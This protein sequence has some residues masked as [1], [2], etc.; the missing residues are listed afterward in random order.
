MIFDIK[1]DDFSRKSRLVSGGHMTE[2][3]DAMTYASVILRET[4]YIA[5]IIAA[6]NRLQVKAADIMNAY[7]T[8]PIEE[9][10]WTVLGPEFVSDA[11]K[12]AVIVLALCGLNLRCCLKQTPGRLHG[13]H[14]I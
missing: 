3:P 10:I 2:A 1:M 13:T 5:L 8:A 12:K 7:I 9:K 14:G 11:G 6:L 4:V